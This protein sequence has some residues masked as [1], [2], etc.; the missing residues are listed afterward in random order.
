M[1]V[2]PQG[3]SS[4][5]G[6]FAASSFAIIRSETLDEDRASSIAATIRLH[7]G[8][9]EFDAY[10]QNRLD[11]ETLTHIVASNADFP[12]YDDAFER[13]LPI[14]R[15]SWVDACVAKDKLANPRQY[16][17][18]PRLFLSDVVVTTAE[19]PQGDSDAIAGG[20]LAMG[21]LY[22]S[23]V[24]SQLTHIVALTMDNDKVIATQVRKMNVKVVLPHWF[25]DCLKLGKRIDEMPYLLPDPEILRMDHEKGPTAARNQNVV[26]AM[27]PDP[28]QSAPRPGV[29]R[30]LDVFKGKAVLLSKDLGLGTNL[31]TIVEGLI[32]RGGGRMTKSV[33]QGTMYVCKY[34]EG[35]DYIKASRKKTDVGN[36]AWLYYIITNNKWTSPLRRMLHYPISRE[37]LPGFQ[38]FRISLSNY[39]G[40]ARLYLENLITASGAECTKTLKQDNTHLVTAHIQSEKCAA[41]KDWGLKIVN[42]LWLEESYARWRVMSET[43]SRYTH[44]P[45]RTNL[46]EIVGQTKLDRR[47]LEAAFFPSDSDVE[48]LDATEASD[49]P[50]SP[51]KRPNF[52]QVPASSVL[53]SPAPPVVNGK[54]QKGLD[55]DEPSKKSNVRTPAP[56]RFAA[57][58]KENETP[59]TGRKAKEDAA[60]KLKELTPDILQYQKETKRVGGVIYGGRRKNDEDRISIGEK[61]SFEEASDSD[62]TESDEPRKVRKT[63]ATP[64]ETV[65]MLIS[66]YK[67]WVGHPKVEDESKRRLRKLGIVVTQDLSRAKIIAVPHLLRTAKFVSAIAYAPKVVSTEY[68]EACLEEEEALDPDDFLLADSASEKK[69]NTKLSTILQRA[70][71]NDHKLLADRTMYCMENI[72][73]GFDAFDQIVKVNG[74]QCN[75]WRGR[76]DIMVPSKR[77]GSESSA[78]EDEVYLITS[79]EKENLKTQI[80]LWEKFSQM[81]EGARKMPKVLKSDWLIESALLQKILP[82]KSYEIDY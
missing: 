21:G 44:F 36:L 4:T 77:A 54:P 62:E 17:P 81:A 79:Q 71:E 42:H 48:M 23:K 29:D 66:G 7:G 65:H 55:T 45:S 16:N 20:V 47:A 13:L 15:P 67:K 32:I 72:F 5:T 18:D 63:S 22:T 39:S 46:G 30:A 14:I 27:H 70:K 37:G 40:E 35:A 34:R 33:N 53:S 75:R 76:H 59:T 10:P 61:R 25:D 9:A 3:D 68:M 64:T 58:G 57:T 78:V 38:D 73:G 56:N 19:L 74:G 28:S 41:A 82:T 50:K 60:V 1:E 80:K 31:R 43:D 12:D 2:D 49:V 51:I 26:G 52:G 6:L 69:Y 24:T 8:Q 11:L